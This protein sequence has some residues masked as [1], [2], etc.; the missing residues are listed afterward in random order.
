MDDYS[1]PPDSS[2]PYC[3]K[4]DCRWYTA[5]PPMD[6]PTGRPCLAC[7]HFV[8]KDLYE[9]WEVEDEKDQNYSAETD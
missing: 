7:V 6:S 2:N 1:A 3:V 9:T 5:Y 8:K 4:T